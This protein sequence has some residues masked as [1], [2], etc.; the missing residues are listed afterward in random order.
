MAKN[1]LELSRSAAV[2]AESLCGR[3]GETNSHFRAVFDVLF[4]ENL[5]GIVEG[6]DEVAP[7]LCPRV[8]PGRPQRRVRLRRRARAAATSR[9]VIW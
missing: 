3:G 8:L 7:R 5:T 4:V 6:R 2:G 1:L 9:L